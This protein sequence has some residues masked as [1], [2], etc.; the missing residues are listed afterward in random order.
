MLLKRSDSHCL[1]VLEARDPPR[2]PLKGNRSSDR[3]KGL[4]WGRGEDGAVL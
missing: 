4:S 1:R 2:P 3:V